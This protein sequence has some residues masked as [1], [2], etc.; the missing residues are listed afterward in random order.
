M[1]VFL[2]YFVKSASQE[3]LLIFSEIWCAKYYYTAVFSSS[4]NIIGIRAFVPN[5]GCLI[6]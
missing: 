2:L 1:V 4:T 5:N 3:N 6:I